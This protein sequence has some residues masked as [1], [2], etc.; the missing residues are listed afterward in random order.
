[1][2]NRQAIREL[3]ARLARRLQEAHTQDASA[4]WLAVQAGGRGYLLP[5]VQSGGIYPLGTV[6]F[7]PYVRSWFKGVVNIRGGLYGVVN[8][9]DFLADKAEPESEQPGVLEPK[10]VVTFNESLEINCALQI[11]SLMGLRG[12]GA[13]KEKAAPEVQAAQYF[14]D[15]FV[16]ENGCEWQE[17]NLR[18]LSCC[19]RFL[20]I[21]V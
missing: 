15:R 4:T 3:Q 5:L 2:A 21:A 17:I 14:A 12:A 1:M 20:N 18:A 6:Q 10:I 8:M 7:V 13:F 19:P 16:D 9:A 11:D